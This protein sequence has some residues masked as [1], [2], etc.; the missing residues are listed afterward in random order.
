MASNAF[1]F[2]LITPQGKVLDAQIT[3]AN[4]PAHDGMIGFL[5]SRAPIVTTLGYGPLSVTLAPA[6]NKGDPTGP[7]S[8]YVEEG[9]VQMVNNKLTVLSTKAIPSEELVESEIK[10]ELAATE[11]KP[12]A[13]MSKRRDTLRAKLRMAQSLSGK[14][15]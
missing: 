15:I 13:D 5:P 14:G 1:Q 9:F 10:N 7:R 11:N 12:G 2:R 3:S 8:Y 4:V 6:L